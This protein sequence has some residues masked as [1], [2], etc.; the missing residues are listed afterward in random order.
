[1]FELM[2]LDTRVADIINQFPIEILDQVEIDVKYD[3]YI[4]RERKLAEKI[5]GLEDFKI[6]TNFDYDR[7]KALSSEAREKLKKIRP[8]TIGQASRISGV[9]PSDISVLTVYM[10][11]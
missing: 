4:D 3:S 9:S 7:V 5:E 6:N 10:G 1:M 8:D 11:R 2:S